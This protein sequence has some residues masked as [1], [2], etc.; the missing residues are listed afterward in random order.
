MAK[1]KWLDRSVIVAP[2]LALCGS[3]KEYLAAVKHLKV[4]DPNIWLTNSSG[5]TTHT[6]TRDDSITCV[7]T[8][9]FKACKNYTLAEIVGILAHEA[10]HVCQQLYDSIGERH[11]SIEFEA[12]AIQCTT[13]RLVAEFLRRKVKYKKEY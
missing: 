1:T 5:G 9:D 6:F 3:E 8:I 11:P 12:Y 7:V 10:T 13:Q 4:K 2:H